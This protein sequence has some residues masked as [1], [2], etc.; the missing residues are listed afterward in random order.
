MV[1][2]LA[3]AVA[4]G[5]LEALRAAA[6]AFGSDLCDA[7]PLFPFT[8]IGGFPIQAAATRLRVDRHIDRR[9]V[10]G[11][12]AI[13]LDVLIASAIG[14]MSL[15][16]LGA[17]IPALVILTAIAVAWIVLVAPYLAPRI[18]PVHWFEHGIADFGQSQ[19][20]VATGFVLADMADP[21]RRTDAA[22][23]YGYKQLTYEPLL[24]GG[25]LTALSVPLIVAFGALT[26]G[27]AATVGTAVLVVWGVRR[28][29][30]A[31][32]PGGV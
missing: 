32:G 20:N 11:I 12:S 2:S 21:A 17:N 18:H 19:G 4:I 5:I 13:A 31:T 1:I 24:G 15:A 3:I 23:A 22:V 25:L 10:S 6:H 8:V 29:R 26:F 14:T 28:R 16:P 9:A 7:F 30:R 27:L